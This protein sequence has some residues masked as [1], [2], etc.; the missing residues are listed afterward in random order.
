MTNQEILARVDHTLLKADATWPQI[1]AICDEAIEAKTASICINTCYVKQAV[2]YM[3][4]RIPVCCV[5]G[6]PLGAMDTASK[7]FEAKTAVENG[8][9]EVDMVI[10]IGWLKD[11]R[12]D[13]VREDIAAVKR[14]VGDKVLKVIIETCLLTDAEKEKMCDIVVEAGADFIKT[15][16]GFSTGGAT[17]HDIALFSRCVAGRCKIK[18]AGGISTREDME[19]FIAL[20]ADRLGTSRAVKILKGE[21]AQGY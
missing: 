10:N 14:A 21:Q 17:F 20:G 4:G 1:K 19:Q 5:I 12:Y 18:A 3:A 16:T 6:F 15:S 7:C 13:A 8:A 2:E 9:A 11:G